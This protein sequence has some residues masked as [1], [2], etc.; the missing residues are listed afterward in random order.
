VG[1][2]LH[3]PILNHPPNGV[4]RDHLEAGQLRLRNRARAVPGLDPLLDAVSVVGYSRGHRHGVFH[5]VQ[6]YRAPE[7]RGDGNFYLQIATR[8]QLLPLPSTPEHSPSGP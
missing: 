3:A 2:V 6:G 7:V 1:T 8:T 4:V 5:H